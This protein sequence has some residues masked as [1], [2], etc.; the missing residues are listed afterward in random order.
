[1]ELTAV[2]A[3]SDDGGSSGRLRRTRGLL[4]PGDLRNCLVALAGSRGPLADVLQHRFGGRGSLA[5]HALGNL[6]LAALAEMHGDFL[7]AIRSAA[8]LLDAR[9][10]VLPS[11]LDPVQLVAELEDGRRLVGE[12]HLTRLG[13][14][15]RRVFLHP[16]RPA[17]A[18]G[19]L[20]AIASADLVTLGPGSL[21][22]SVL[23]NLLVDGVSEALRTT[24][25]RRVLVANLMTEPGETGG[26]TAVDHVRAVLEHAGPVVDV[27][28]LNSAP[29]GGHGWSGMPGPGPS[30]SRP[31]SSASGPSGW[32][33][34]TPISSRPVPGSA[35]MPGSSARR[36]SRWS[37]VR[38]EREAPGAPP[39]EGWTAAARVHTSRG[40]R[41]SRPYVP[42]Q[43][44]LGW[45]QLR[46][47]PRPLTEHP[48][49]APSVAWTHLGRNALHLA[50]RVLG[51]EGREVLVPAYH[52]GVEVDA[53]LSAGAFPA[54]YGVG[55][56][57]SL[58]VEDVERAH[59]APDR[60]ASCSPISAGFPGPAEPAPCPGRPSRAGR[61]SRTAPRRC[62]RRTDDVPVGTTGDAAVFS[63]RKTLPVPHGGAL[64]FNGAGASSSRPSEPLRRV[65]RRVASSR[66]C[67]GGASSASPPRA[68]RSGDSGRGSR[69]GS[70]CR[71]CDRPVAERGFDRQQL[72]VGS[73]HRWSSASPGPRRW[74]SVVERRRRNFFHLLGALRGG[75]PPL[76]NELPTGVCPLFYPLWV[77]DKDEV[78]ARLRAENVEAGAGWRAFHSRCD[79]GEFPEA[80]RLRQHLLELPC[81]QD[82]R[83]AH[84]AHVARVA[85]GR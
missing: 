21:Y 84:V 48:F 55:A 1:M 29:L 22:S 26:M 70:G 25:A 76:V 56:R 16:L 33:R 3:M 68:A 50:A 58:D 27:A 62:C 74:P 40:C 45:E 5:G 79:G 81:H 85:L 39:G 63:F 42:A 51:L 71:A 17:P 15:V 44:T 35:T 69:G 61:S 83:P 13:A 53:L 38:A 54:F 75:A 31:I 32:C 80:S 82:L 8:R 49:S 6:L 72:A 19:V 66:G 11:T 12:H 52:H 9:G 78:L 59:R 10:T 30:R 24:R 46:A 65:R 73:L 7:E 57:W 36:C 47:P 43:P 64:V 34:W 67:C 4:P 41:T 2:V 28:L 18:E 60:W 14:R 77:E 23:P 37:P 20:E